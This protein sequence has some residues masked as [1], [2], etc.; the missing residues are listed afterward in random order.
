MLHIRMCADANKIRIGADSRHVRGSWGC[1]VSVA[2]GEGG[3]GG[4]RELWG[5]VG[6][7][8]GVYF[9]DP[10]YPGEW[11]E[12]ARELHLGN[13]RRLT[14]GYMGAETWGEWAAG[15]AAYYA[16][17]A[18]HRCGMLSPCFARGLLRR[19]AGLYREDGGRGALAGAG[20]CGWVDAVFGV[21]A[22]G[23]L[24]GGVCV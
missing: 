7:M 11:G 9:G 15:V 12:A 14:L 20:V 6:K 23:R 3:W 10:G 22:G 4:L 21:E 5:V 18:E 1:I 17:V 8:V 19:T 13:L 16:Y 24:R 2:C